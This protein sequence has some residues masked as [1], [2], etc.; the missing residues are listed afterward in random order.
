[1]VPATISEAEALPL[2][3]RTAKYYTPTGRC[4]QVLDYTHRREDG[5]V[6][7]IP[8]S[9]KKEFKTTRGRIV[10]DGGGIDP[11]IALKVPDAANITQVIHSHGFLIDYASLYVFQHPTIAPAKDFSLSDAEYQDFVNWMKD[12][13][14]SYRSKVEAELALFTEDA[15]KERYYNDLKP[16]LDQLRSK[17]AESHKGDLH[18][19]KDQIKLLLE[20]EIVTHYYLEQGAVEL[21]FKND[22]EV[23]KAI[24]LLNNPGQYKKILNLQ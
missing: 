14:Y 21:G 11:D 8:D 12:K 23:K 19:F 10:Y 3:M 5:S 17:L 15:K 9:L 2:L 18:T 13:Q 24:E 6:G 16:Q 1:M 20:K 22:D 7:S 4:I